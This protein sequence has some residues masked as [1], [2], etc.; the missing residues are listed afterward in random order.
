MFI[1]YQLDFDDILALQRD[2][3]KHSYTHKIK[4]SYFKWISAVI[5]F[6]A[7]LFLF[8]PSLISATVGLVITVIYVIAFPSLYE[9]I[10][11][12]RAKSKMQQQDYEHILAPCD[13]TLNDEGITRV[14]N[15]ETTH[16][17]WDT[18]TRIGEDSSHYFLYQTELQGLI[19]PK[20]PEQLSSNDLNE[21]Q[22]LIHKWI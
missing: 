5:I 15:D 22:T 11:F 6:L 12:S 17:D 18:F 14:M 2:V 3:I 16:F 10:T 19:L 8:G 13:L 21:Y 1:Y 7:L 4:K 9:K 20:K